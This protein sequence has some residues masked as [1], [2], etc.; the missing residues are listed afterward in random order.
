MPKKKIE[1]IVIG[2][3]NKGKIKEIRDLIPKKYKI[4]T[5]GQ[6]KL[7]S[8]VENGKSFKENSLIKAKNFSLKTNM[9][10]IADDSGL[11]IDLL[12]KKP[13]IYS[14]RWGGSKGDFNLAIKKVFKALDKKKKNWREEKIPA[15]F[16]CALTIFG[17]KKKPIFSVGK[18]EGYI[19]NEQRGLMALVMILYLY[20][21]EKEKL[22]VRWILKKNIKL[23]TDTKLLKKLENFYKF[24]IIDTVKI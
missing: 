2:S 24:F 14:A 16:I 6:F 22:L 11:E 1:K 20:L 8:P 23:T 21:K 15:R 13:G 19:S 3:N 9:V 5:P 18:I 12:N 4:S 7:K 17:L 10:C